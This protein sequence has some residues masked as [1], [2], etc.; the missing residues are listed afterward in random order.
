MPW[1][2]MAH[3]LTALVI[4]TWFLPLAWDRYFLSVQAGGSVLAAAGLCHWLRPRSP[5]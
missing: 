1:F 2:V 4:V 5:S 3:A